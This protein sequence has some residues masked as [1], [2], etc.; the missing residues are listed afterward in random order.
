MSQSQVQYDP[1]DTDRYRRLLNTAFNEILLRGNTSNTGTVTLTANA[2]TTTV[3]NSR[4]GKEQFIDFMPT[5]EN[6]AKELYGGT[7]YV[8]SQNNGEFTITHN[9]CTATDRTFRY[10]FFG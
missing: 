8:S 3:K 4:V 5:T 6:A 7:M 2:T 9:N 10:V 1:K